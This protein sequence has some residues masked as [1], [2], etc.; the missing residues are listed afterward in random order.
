MHQRREDEIQGT[1]TPVY[2]HHGPTLDGIAE[3]APEPVDA[4]DATT[5]A[6]AAEPAPEPPAAEIEAVAE[7]SA[8]VSRS[9]S[10]WDRE[11]KPRRSIAVAKPVLPVSPVGRR[12]RSAP[13]AADL[14]RWRALAN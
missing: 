7:P 8:P 2:E 6:L 10:E 13:T 3:P 4:A 11:Q 9:I 5:A 1:G 14:A 12:E